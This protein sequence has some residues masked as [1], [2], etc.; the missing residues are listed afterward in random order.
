VTRC[1]FVYLFLYIA[2][3]YTGSCLMR[4]L[5]SSFNSIEIIILFVVYVVDV[6]N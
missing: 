6:F 5:D 3:F 4:N 2:I 1:K